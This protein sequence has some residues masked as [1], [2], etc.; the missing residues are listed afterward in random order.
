MT[1]PWSDLGLP[2]FLLASVLSFAGDLKRA[3]RSLHP[4][5]IVQL[6]GLIVD[7][8]D[9]VLVQAGATKIIRVVREDPTPPAPSVNEKRASLSND[10]FARSAN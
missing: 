6:P 5:H 7:R 10:T 2:G 3:K 9:G 1:G 8:V 4:P